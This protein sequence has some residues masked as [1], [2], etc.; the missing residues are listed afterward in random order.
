MELKNN[1]FEPHGLHVSIK[2]ALCPRRGLSRQESALYIGVSPSLFDDLVK[3]GEMTKP[4]RIKRRT[5]WD[6]HQPDECFEA[7]Y[8]P[9]ENP[10]GVRIGGDGN[11]VTLRLR[12][13]VSDTDRHGTV[14]YYFRRK[15]ETKVHL[16]GAPGSKEFMDAY[17]L[18]LSSVSSKPATPTFEVKALSVSCA[19]NFSRTRHLRR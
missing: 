18:A 14:R 6:R 15:G 17:A 12:F 2:K 8:V 19:E 3:S 4:L 16:R 9:D 7:L 11:M 5:V 1:L 13:A 10:W